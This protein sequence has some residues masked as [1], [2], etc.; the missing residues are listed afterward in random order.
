[1][2]HHNR[3]A[4][5]IKAV[6]GG[7]L[8]LLL[9]RWIWIVFSNSTGEYISY[10]LATTG[11]DINFVYKGQPILDNAYIALKVILMVSGGFL[12][13][14]FFWTLTEGT[15]LIHKIEILLFNA[16]ACIVNDNRSYIKQQAKEI[17]V[18]FSLLLIIQGGILI[19]FLFSMPY[20]YDEMLTYMSFSGKGLLADITYYPVPNNHILYNIVASFFL[21]LPI[22]TLIAIRLPNILLSFISTYYVFKLASLIFNNRAAIIVSAIFAF[23]FSFIMYSVQARGYGFFLFFAVALLYSFARLVSGQNEKKYIIVYA[24][25]AILGAYTMPT[26]I[27]ILFPV[28]LLLFI[29]A[30]FN[31]R[32]ISKGSFFKIHTAIGLLTFLLYLPLFVVNG[33]N[34]F[35]KAEELGVKP[36]QP[37]YTNANIIS[38]LQ[39]TWGYLMSGINITPYILI[40]FAGVLLIAAIRG[41]T[42]QRYIMWLMLLLII[43][44][45]LIILLQKSIPFPRTWSYLMLPLAISVGLITETIFISVKSINE[46]KKLTVA[47]VL[48]TVYGAA[49]F[50]LVGKMY[51][52]L[53]AVDYTV[54][55][56]VSI[57]QNRIPFIKSIQRTNDLSFYLAEDLQYEA[58]QVNSSIQQSVMSVTDSQKAELIISIPEGNFPV[59]NNYRLV[60]LDNPYF[61]VYLR[62]DL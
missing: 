23:S 44:P 37:P 62:K 10:I 47:A 17:K 1:M 33:W 16:M 39:D 45:V 57:L 58:K 12:S 8:L 50:G 18:F 52:G 5:Y 51:H 28:A 55:D 29:Y 3:T 42:A 13:Y 6:I 56:Y 35:Q 32:V 9:W 30:V 31:H 19:Y 53:Y 46:K 11:R 24:I 26:F 36:I 49:M 2:L 21:I 59:S 14:R 25:S 41:A 54:R 20:H 48:I 7:L 4:Y 27:Y 43:S 22:D 40:L 60:P 61:K 38:H 34:V 15:P